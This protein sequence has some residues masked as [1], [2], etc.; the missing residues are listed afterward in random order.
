MIG[1][2]KMGGYIPCSL[3]FSYAGIYPPFLSCQSP[4]NHRISTSSKSA[5][6]LNYKGYYTY[7]LRSSGQPPANAAPISSEQFSVITRPS[8]SVTDSAI[9]PTA[10]FFKRHT[11]N[12]I[13]L[14]S[15]PNERSDTNRNP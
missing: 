7:L 13:R 10:L 1:K 11:D 8:F 4:G 9:I 5:I 3:L 2:I 6:I 14:K 15:S 12:R